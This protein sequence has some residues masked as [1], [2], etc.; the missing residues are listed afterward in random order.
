MTLNQVW[1]TN[2]S[3]LAKESEVRSRS[4]DTHRAHETFRAAGKKCSVIAMVD[5]TL[6]HVEG[7]QR[8]RE[9]RGLVQERG[10]SRATLTAQAD[11][12]NEAVAGHN[13]R[14]SR[15][16]HKATPRRTLGGM[17]SARGNREDSLACLETSVNSTERS[18]NASS[19]GTR[20]GSAMEHEC[21][22]L[23][24]DPLPPTTAST[25]VPVAAPVRSSPTP[26]AA[27][28]MA[29]A[30]PPA[31]TPIPSPAPAIEPA[32]APSVEPPSSALPPLP[33]EPCP[34]A[35]LQ[36]LA[37]VEASGPAA[38][39]LVGPPPTETVP[40]PP[41]AGPP[42]LA[43]SGLAS[44]G[45]PSE[46]PAPTAAIADARG[47][48]RPPTAAAAAPSCAGPARLDSARRAVQPRPPPPRKG[49]AFSAG[50]RRLRWL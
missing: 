8:S 9:S 29:M 19:H 11:S 41:Q 16:E 14:V 42:T 37:P 21:G 39:A 12:G 24:T 15:C 48:Q 36:L 31:H 50:R 1:V 10:T 47:E 27:P 22:T 5:K 49:P 20:H 2:P 26:A 32:P 46:D 13:S 17:D 43:V 6:R 38:S 40:L 45:E 44:R 4:E 30:A 33:R 28:G 35:P 25:L 23:A 7:R 18:N 3:D 34:R